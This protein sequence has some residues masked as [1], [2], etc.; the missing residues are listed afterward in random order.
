MIKKTLILFLLIFIFIS[1]TKDNKED[2]KVSIKSDDVTIET[3]KKPES[4]VLKE[5]IETNEPKQLTE[6]KNA[7]RSKNKDN[8]S[9]ESTEPKK[10]K[11]TD[12][13]SIK[14]EN[15][16]EIKD[17]ILYGIVIND[18]VNLYK[19]HKELEPLNEISKFEKVIIENDTEWIAFDDGYRKFYQLNIDGNKEI[20]IDTKDCSLILNEHNNLQIGIIENIQSFHE[21][22]YGDPVEAKLYM[23]YNYL[24]TI[25]NKQILVDDLNY[26]NQESFHSGSQVTHI[27]TKEL[28]NDENIEIIVR[29]IYSGFL[30]YGD[31]FR[32]AGEGWFNINENK[33]TRIFGHSIRGGGLL[34]NK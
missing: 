12:L 17:K 31:G 25:E 20:Y 16:R 9:T 13:Q 8:E 15:F 26:S 34:V 7:I 27:E 2:Q 22:A 19:I 23:I 11:I 24:V 14:D 4:K 6:L 33:L 21:D 5:P 32:Y 10:F 3:N 28:N 18:N 1:C 29:T 30:L